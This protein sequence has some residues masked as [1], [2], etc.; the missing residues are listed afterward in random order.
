MNTAIVACRSLK[1]EL[2]EILG[3]NWS[4]KIFYL[5]QILHLYPQRLNLVLDRILPKVSRSYGQIVVVYGK[6]AVNIDEL[7]RKHGAVRVPGELCYEMFA[8]DAFFHLLREKPGTYFLTED[9]CRNFEKLL[10]R[11]LKW[12]EKPKLKEI[13]LQNYSRAVFLDTMSKGS[14]DEKAQEIA[15]YLELPLEIKRVGL[16]NFKKCILQ[17]MENI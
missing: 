15:N 6:C 11:P 10:V 2:N 1:S 4:G 9:L 8:G 7:I 16:A 12:D 17:T 14:L 3:S 5:P 13:M